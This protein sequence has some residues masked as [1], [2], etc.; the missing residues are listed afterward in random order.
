MIKRIP[1]RLNIFTWKNKRCYVYLC[2]GHQTVTMMNQCC[3]SFDGLWK[4]KKVKYVVM[5]LNVLAELQN[6][7]GAS[8]HPALMS[9]CPTCSHMPCSYQSTNWFFISRFQV[10]YRA[11]DF[12]ATREVPLEKKVDMKCMQVS[13][14]KNIARMTRRVF[15]TMSHVRFR[16]NLH[17]VVAWM[18]TNSLP[19]TQNMWSLSDNGIRTHN[20]Y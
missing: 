5:C 16:V 9:N 18:P 6:G 7:M 11:W 2:R 15:F 1:G 17:S 4:V 12:V 19:E 8:H 20:H 10:V 13:V 3:Y 14:L